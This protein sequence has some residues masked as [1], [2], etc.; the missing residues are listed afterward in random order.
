ME[1]GTPRPPRFWARTSPRGRTRVSPGRGL[2]PP[3]PAVAKLWNFAQV[4]RGGRPALSPPTRSRVGKLSVKDKATPTVGLVATRETTWPRTP[5]FGAP[6]S[7][8]PKVSPKGTSRPPPVRP[9]G[10]RLRLCDRVSR[11]QLTETACRSWKGFGTWFPFCRGKES[12]PFSPGW[13]SQSLWWD[14][15]AAGGGGS[16]GDGDRIGPRGEGRR[17]RWE[18][19]AGGPEGGDGHARPCLLR[20]AARAS[21]LPQPLGAAL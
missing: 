20:A 4:P 6:E 16:P 12:C 2:G 14:P 21:C 3:A 11:L 8:P 18:A 7:N 15:R 17:E 9:P 19:G 13:A 10:P 1:G 5:M